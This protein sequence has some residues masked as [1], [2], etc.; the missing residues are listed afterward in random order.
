MATHPSPVTGAALP[1][2]RRYIGNIADHARAL[3]QARVRFPGNT[4]GAIAWIAQQLGHS[5]PGFPSDLARTVLSPTGGWRQVNDDPWL[6]DQELAEHAQHLADCGVLVVA[7]HR[8]W[9][10]GAQPVALVAPGGMVKPKARRATRKNPKTP[11][12]R[13]PR[14]LAPRLE[15]FTGQGPESRTSFIPTD[16]AYRQAP[17][18]CVTGGR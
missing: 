5:L 4:A 11:A 14:P 9:E 15:D 6:S 10:T 8:D 7:I 17:A 2:P 12:V 1:T 18:W 13:T 3:H 16:W